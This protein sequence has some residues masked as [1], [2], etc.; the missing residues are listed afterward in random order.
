MTNKYKISEFAKDFGIASKE[1][2][3]M[4][5]DITGEEKK[6]GASLNET[7]IAL[8]LTFYFAFWLSCTAS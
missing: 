8:L 2:I 5:K 1:I 4:V 7:E 3:A 6:S